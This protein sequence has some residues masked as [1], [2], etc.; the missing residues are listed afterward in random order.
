MIR[1]QLALV[2]EVEAEVEEAD[3]EGELRGEWE[4]LAEGGEEGIVQGEGFLCAA[5][6]SIS[7]LSPL[8]KKRE[9][10]RRD[11]VRASPGCTA[12]RA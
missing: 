2:G 12:R 6:L 5:S 11:D 1:P 4:G 9:R 10:V 7:T 8:C 3:A